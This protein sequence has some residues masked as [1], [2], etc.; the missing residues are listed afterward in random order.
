MTSGKTSFGVGRAVSSL[1]L[2][3]AAALTTALPAFAQEAPAAPSALAT[4]AANGAAQASGAGSYTPMAPTPGIGMPVDGGIGL[5]EQFSKVGEYG[6]AIHH[7]LLWV[8]GLITLF[9]LLLLVIVAVRFNRRSNPIA[10]KTSHNTLLEVV[11]TL[12]PVLILVGIAVPSID[13]IAKQYKPAPKDA[14][15]I[16][17]TGNQWFWTYGYPDNGDFEVISNMLNVPGA[18]VINNGVREVGSQ[19]WDGPSQL[20]V[21]NRMVVPVG[22]PIR[23]QITAADVIHSF[24]IPSLW[25][26][27]DAVPGRINEKVL[28]IEKPGVYYGQC[29]ELCGVKHA[30]MPIAIEALPRDKYNAWV[31]THA[32]GE[33]DGQD[34]PAPATAAPV[35]TAD[36]SEAPVVDATAEAE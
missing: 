29:S 6:H 2:S 16:K 34:K 11:W 5:Q 18:P 9:V 15:T 12:L 14:L 19:P 13:L 35:P 3:L 24:A 27:L 36:A 20:E 8:I 4:G 21:D 28:V 17:V 26:K 7:G 1:A 31:L 10:S 23:L 32:G 33:I 25:F 22:E 30:Y